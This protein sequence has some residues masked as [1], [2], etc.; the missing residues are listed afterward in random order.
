MNEKKEILKNIL[1]LK[2]GESYFLNMCEESGGEIYKASNSKYVLYE[3]NYG[4]MKVHD[5][6]TLGDEMVIIEEILSWT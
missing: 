5:T 6:Y 1:N 4:V 2:V 3:V